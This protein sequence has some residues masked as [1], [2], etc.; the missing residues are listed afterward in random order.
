MNSNFNKWYA[1]W[2]KPETVVLDEQYHRADVEIDGLEEFEE[3][4]FEDWF[5]DDLIHFVLNVTEHRIEIGSAEHSYT[6]G[7]EQIRVVETENRNMFWNMMLVVFVLVTIYVLFAAWDMLDTVAS[8]TE[9]PVE[10]GVYAIGAFLLRRFLIKI[11]IGK[12]IKYLVLLVAGTIFTV[13]QKMRRLSLK[14]F[15]QDQIVPIVIY[16]IRD[17]KLI[18]SVCRAAIKQRQVV[19]SSS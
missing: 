1:A 18:E 9:I 8:V 6:I 2:R 10:Q 17:A 14:I 15:I 7:L 4:L 11:L 5:D 13:Y 16:N 12:K 19:S 3:S